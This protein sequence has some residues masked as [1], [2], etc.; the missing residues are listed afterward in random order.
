MNY[1][2]ALS[3]AENLLGNPQFMKF[4]A[5]SDADEWLFENGFEQ[6][7]TNGVEF[8]SEDGHRASFVAKLEIEIY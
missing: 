3:A 8:R 6:C 4:D 2:T 5:V 1:S 7:D